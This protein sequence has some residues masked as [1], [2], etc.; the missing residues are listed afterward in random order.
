MVDIKKHVMGRTTFQFYKQGN[1]YYKTDTGF[2]FF[3]PLSD[4]GDASFL[5]EDK[6]IFFMRWIRKTLEIQEQG[7]ETSSEVEYHKKAIDDEYN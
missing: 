7:I 3:V 4:T 6:S 1:L 5:N 2:E